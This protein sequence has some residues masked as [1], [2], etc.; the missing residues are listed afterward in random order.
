MAHES[1]VLS[2]LP[3]DMRMELEDHYQK[4]RATYV[5]AYRRFYLLTRGFDPAHYGEG[6]LLRLDGGTCPDTGAVFQPF[7]PRLS[8][9]AFGQG[10]SPFDLIEGT[11]ATWPEIDP[12]RPAQLLQLAS[13]DKCRAWRQGR[14]AR[15]GSRVRAD[16]ERAASFILVRYRASE[17]QSAPLAVAQTLLAALEDTGDLS[18]LLKTVLAHRFGQEALVERYAPAA[19]LD[20][21]GCQ[22]EWDRLLPDGQLPEPV[23]EYARKYQSTAE[24]AGTTE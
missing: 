16:L 20:Y 17:Q 12:P 9:F 13:V 23:K 21:L 22:E 4:L 10:L 15:L 14:L 11:F 8:R 3:F 19:A 18:P 6:P 24:P 5:V 7:W 1:I 2:E